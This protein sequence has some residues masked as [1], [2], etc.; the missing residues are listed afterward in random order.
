VAFDVKVIKGKR[1]DILRFSDLQFALVRKNGRLVKME[2]E[3]YT[4]K[5]HLEIGLPEGITFLS[6]SHVQ[7]APN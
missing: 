7:V 2:G 5:P 1:G 6:G 4:M 3:K